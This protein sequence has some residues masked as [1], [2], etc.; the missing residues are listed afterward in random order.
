[1][2]TLLLITLALFITLW[3]AL[4]SVLIRVLVDILKDYSNVNYTWVL[5]G[6]LTAV[7]PIL[8]ALSYALGVNT[9]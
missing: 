3:L 2:I 9:K 4:N 6:F 7:T 8:M 5:Y 1:M